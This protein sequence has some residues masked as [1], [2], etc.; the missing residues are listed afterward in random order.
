MARKKAAPAQIK[1]RLPEALRR[2]LEREAAKNRRTL[3][4]EIVHRL[5]QPFEQAD[6][7][8]IAGAAADEAYKRLL[9]SIKAIDPVLRA[10]PEARPEARRKADEEWAARRK[11]VWPP[12]VI[13][14]A[15][16]LV[17]EGAEIDVDVAIGRILSAKTDEGAAMRRLVSEQKP[18]G[19]KK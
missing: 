7:K 16:Q 18:E 13:L 3:N 17:K 19:E 12:E 6:R 15:E 2:D 4:G 11:E 5:T 9:G 8:A 10:H 1:I 14:K